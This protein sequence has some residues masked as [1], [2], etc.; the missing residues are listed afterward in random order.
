MLEHPDDRALGSVPDEDSFHAS[1]DR[2]HAF[3]KQ[4]SLIV[5]NQRDI[6]T[7]ERERSAREISSLIKKA[8]DKDQKLEYLRKALTDIQIEL[9]NSRRE[10]NSLRLEVK[11]MNDQLNIYK[12]DMERIE[13]LEEEVR[14]AKDE[15][16]ALKNQIEVLNANAAKIQ[17]EHKTELDEVTLK[18]EQEKVAMHESIQI[19][20][21]KL[22][23]AEQNC[24]KVKALYSLSEK[25]KTAIQEENDRYRQEQKRQIDKLQDELAR[26]E[27]LSSEQERRITDMQREYEHKLSI[28][29]T[30]AEQNYHSQIETL[31]SSL[32][33]RQRELNLSRYQIEQLKEDNKRAVEAIK[34]DMQNQ[35]NLRA[36]EIR[37]QFILKAAKSGDLK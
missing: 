19:V 32:E 11:Q 13:K 21:D 35:L 28:S 17:R 23:L 37:R 34:R 10:E 25:E 14:A 20:E 33:D 15:S 6:I 36:D 27:A 4:M 16:A 3:G 7:T 29:L 12:V 5:Q 2:I 24:E 1:V 8:A 9:S 26:Q 18:C 22:R 30:K 31:K